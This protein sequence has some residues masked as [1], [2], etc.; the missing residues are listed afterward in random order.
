MFDYHSGCPDVKYGLHGVSVVA[1]ARGGT[2]G[3]IMSIS[4][5]DSDQLPGGLA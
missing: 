3:G 2:A 1:E 5:T 4:E